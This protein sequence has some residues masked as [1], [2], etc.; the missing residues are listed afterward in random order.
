MKKFTFLNQLVLGIGLLAVTNLQAQGTH[1]FPTFTKVTP[2][3]A[4]Q[5]FRGN[6]AWGDYNNDG[7]M[8][9]IYVGRDIADGWA[10]HIVLLTNNGTSFDISQEFGLPASGIYNAV[11][12]WIDYNNDGNLDLLY[13]GTTN[14]E[15]SSAA[16]DVFAYLYKN[17]GSAGNFAFE[18]VV[19]T[20]L[21]GY[22][23]D[24]EGNY[25]SVASIGDYNNDGYADILVTGAVDGVRYV[26]LYKNNE[27]TGSF[28]KQEKMIDGFF[29]FDGM[30][31]GCV[32]FGDMNKD[33][34]LDVL[35][36]GWNDNAND[37][38]I[39]MYKNLGDGAFEDMYIE[40][41]AEGTQKGQIGWLDLN[42]DGN[43]DFVVTG[44]RME[45]GW[46]KMADIYVNNGD[47]TF[48][49]KTSTETFIDPLKNA[50]IDYADM[51]NDGKTDLIMAG[52]GNEQHS[53]IYLNNGDFTF[54]AELNL[55]GK[56]RSGALAIVADYNN[57]GFLDGFT[58]GYGNDA[59]EGSSDGSTSM[60]WKNNGGGTANTKPNAPKNLQASYAAGKLTL[61]WDAATD[62]ETPAAALKY[63]V[64]VKK[65]DAQTLMLVPADVTTGYVKVSDLTNA[66]IT[67]SYTISLADG[68][69][70]WGV[71]TIDQGKAGSVFATA[72]YQGSGIDDK[73]INLNVKAYQLD[74]SIFVSVD[75]Q[76]ATVTVFDLSGKQ[77]VREAR[78]KNGIINYQFKKGLY[79][80]NIK[81]KNGQVTSKISVY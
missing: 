38:L 71:Q 62:A 50:G 66:V 45:G 15:T 59:A 28:T 78:S 30:S 61:T 81:N 39:K 80:V 34:M 64:F 41:T 74:G 5:T 72:V 76:P 65:D 73:N 44:E 21:T 18:Q 37:A 16:A 24:Q 23:I 42:N 57:D 40:D 75:D 1:V 63:N 7:K 60:V 8:D 68:T 11:L 4:P 47:G 9:L 69:Y 56:V 77:L 33:G 19:E 67:T 10:T 52:E 26:D 2:E 25:G 32:A 29:N 17:T 70:Q 20:G 55:L 48:A 54:D 27:G 53:W 31:S 36:T 58:C 51:D 79:L 43:L 35:A 12:N 22:Y 13:I 14:S 6:G 46:P 3:G 49:Q